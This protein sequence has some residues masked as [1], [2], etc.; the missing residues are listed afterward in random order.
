MKAAYGESVRRNP[1]KPSLA[2]KTTVIQQNTAW[3]EKD[4]S[5]FDTTSP[6]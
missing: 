4:Y 2:K 5:I 3:F 1:Y 6:P